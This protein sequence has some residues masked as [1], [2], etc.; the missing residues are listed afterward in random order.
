MYTPIIEVTYNEITTKYMAID[1]LAFKEKYSLRG[2]VELYY[3]KSL[4]NNP[5]LIKKDYGSLFYA[6]IISILGA[7][8]TLAV[9]ID[10]L[11]GGAAYARL[12]PWN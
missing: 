5:I 10:R 7:V 6:M 2:N 8:L 9:I 12:R 11:Q 1:N 3:N 4:R